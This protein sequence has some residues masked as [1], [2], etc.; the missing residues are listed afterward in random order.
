MDVKY[1]KVSKNTKDKKKT[2]KKKHYSCRASCITNSLMTIFYTLHENCSSVYT[3]HKQVRPT[4]A[5]V[6]TKEDKVIYSLDNKT[7]VVSCF[8][9]RESRL[10]M[11]NM[12]GTHGLM[13]C[14]Q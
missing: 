2:K 12:F 14:R 13:L 6:K 3:H 1:G 10:K 9:E 11:A 8:T 5:C 7:S 4:C